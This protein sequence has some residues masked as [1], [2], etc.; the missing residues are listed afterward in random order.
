M[1]KISRLGIA[2]FIAT[3]AGSVA[4][5]GVPRTVQKAFNGEILITEV[6]F[7]AVAGSGVE[8]IETLEKARLHELEPLDSTSST[9]M[10][11]FHFIA[12]LDRAPRIGELSLDFYTT[13]GSGRYVTSQ[14]L[15][16]IDPAI[17]ILSG[18]V[19]LSEDDGLRPGATYR[20]K[21]TGVVR[22]RELIFATTTVTLL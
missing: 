13:D 22:G 8:L 7:R 19:T 6:S 14:R 2:L 10:W 11:G 9:L 18:D 3:C 21:L 5:A 15:M 12:F 1:K 4:S 16:G 17:R 20:V